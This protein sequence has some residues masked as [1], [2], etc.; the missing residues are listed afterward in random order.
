[1]NLEE[2]PHFFFFFLNICHTLCVSRK[3]ILKSGLLLMKR[4]T[5]NLI[6]KDRWARSRHFYL[7]SLYVA[8]KDKVNKF[9][10]FFLMSHLMCFSTHR[11]GC[12]GRFDRW[13]ESVRVEIAHTH[14]MWLCG[15]KVGNHKLAPEYDQIITTTTTKNAKSFDYCQ[16]LLWNMTVAT[17]CGV[18]FY[19]LMPL[20][21]IENRK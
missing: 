11:W 17:L 10:T 9:F 3:W 14:L 12:H 19:I 15:L 1:M 2:Y 7:L 16:T 6:K 8:T 5:M 20:N 13:R 21:Q 18:D 4:V